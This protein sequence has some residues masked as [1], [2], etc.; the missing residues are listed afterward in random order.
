MTALFLYFALGI[1]LGACGITVIDKPW[2]FFVIM[3]I[4]VGIDLCR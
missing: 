1:A 4:V 3:A 2:Q